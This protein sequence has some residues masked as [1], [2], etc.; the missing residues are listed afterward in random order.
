M[1]ESIEKQ[2][3]TL[4]NFCLGLPSDLENKKTLKLDSVEEMS[5]D[6]KFIILKS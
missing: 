2:I 1:Q 5:K 3:N 6:N 4:I